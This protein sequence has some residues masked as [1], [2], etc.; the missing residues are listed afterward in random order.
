MARQSFPSSAALVATC[1]VSFE[2]F[3]ERAG[4]S[5]RLALLRECCARAADRSVRLVC[6]P[7]GYLFCR[8]EAEIL[9]LRKQLEHL[10]AELSVTVA[11]GVD[12]AKKSIDKAEGTE[13]SDRIRSKL[14][15]EYRLPWFAVCAY[16][17]GTSDLWRQRSINSSNQ[18]DA[19]DDCC[20]EFHGV[21]GLIPQTEIFTCG[22]IFNERIRAG[23]ISRGTQLVVD[24]GH[25]GHGFRV[26]AAMKVLA[27]QGVTSLC[28]VHADKHNATK[29][30][31]VPNSS[32]YMA[33]STT[34]SDFTVEREPRVEMKV[35]NFDT[36]RLTASSGA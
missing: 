17:D 27:S 29:Y 11:V 25:Y 16:P 34:R 28:S 30:C 10:S 24:L 3:G 22:E 8:S 33:R 26:H 5:D 7:G 4:M 12:T 1:T 21:R 18:Y 2:G 14:I 35:W 9:E 36:L 13:D 15:R 6:F 20:S 31:Y 23:V 32:G 19:P